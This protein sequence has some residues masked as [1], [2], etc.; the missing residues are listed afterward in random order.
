MSDHPRPRRIPETLPMDTLVSF[1]AQRSRVGWEETQWQGDVAPPTSVTGSSQVARLIA[2]GEPR[3]EPGMHLYRVVG[4][5]GFGEV[6]EALQV[7]LD[8]VVAVKRL[9]EETARQI[10]PNT[11]D[12]DAVANF[13]R[14]EARITARLEHPNIAPMHE[15]S[16]DSAGHPMLAMKMLRGTPWNEL[17]RGDF[18]VMEDPQFLERHL[19]ILA[20]M[21]QAV[22]FAHS[23]GVI[24]RDLKPTQVM[25][26]EFGEVLLLDWGLAVVYD[27]ERFG[28]TQ[29][30]VP[31]LETASSPAGTVAFMAPEQTEDD[32]TGVS[33]RTDVWLLGGCL[34]YILTGQL[35]HA[36][37]TARDT[38]FRAMEGVILPPEVRSPHRLIPRVLSDLSM[39][40]LQPQP[41]DRLASA[42]DF[43]QQLRDYLSG[44][45]RRREAEGL[46]RQARGILAQQR[47]WY[48]D[49]SA[50]AATLSRA[51]GLA[52][53]LDEVHSA[54]QQLAE[55]FAREALDRGDLALA[56]TQVE[57]LDSG[58]L[59]AEMEDRVRVRAARLRATRSQRTV[60]IAASLT[61]ATLL[62]IGGIYYAKE[63][64]RSREEIERALVAVAEQRDS[65]ERLVQEMLGDLQTRLSLLGRLDLMEDV[66]RLT[67]QYY[68]SMPKGDTVTSR[69]MTQRGRA[70]R[71]IGDVILSRGYFTEAES[72]YQDARQ[73]LFYPGSADIITIVERAELLLSMDNQQ[74]L[75][76]QGTDGK[77]IEEAIALLTPLLDSGVKT[78]ELLDT[79]ARA[80]FSQAEVASNRGELEEAERLYQ[81]SRAIFESLPKEQ[82]PAS[83][84]YDYLSLRSRIARIH[85]MLGK[86]NEAV[87][88]YED[89]VETLREQMDRTPENML[90][91]TLLASDMD[92]L[93]D[94]QNNL[95]QVARAAESLRESRELWD[96]LTLAQPDRVYAWHGSARNA[97]YLGTVEEV[98][99]SLPAAAAAYERAWEEFGQMLRR[100]ATSAEARR[101]RNSTLAR[102]SLVLLRMGHQD[103]AMALIRDS[104]AECEAILSATPDDAEVLNLLSIQ[105]GRLGDLLLSRGRFGE[106]LEEQQ[107]GI[108]ILERRFFDR[109]DYSPYRRQLVTILNR[110]VPTLSAMGRW[111]EALGRSRESEVIARRIA[112]EE[113]ENIAIRR[114]LAA[115]LIRQAP[116]HYSHR[117]DLATALLVAKEAREILEQ[118]AAG[119]FHAQVQREVSFALSAEARVHLRMQSHD[120]AREL[121]ESA[122]AI[123]DNL[124][125]QD[126]SHLGFQADRSGFHAALGEL[127]LR[128]GQ[129]ALALEHSSRCAEIIASL[130]ERLAGDRSMTA[131]LANSLTVEARAHLGIGDREAAAAA[132]TRA[133][134]LLEPF[135]AEYPDASIL[136]PLLE[137]YRI[138]GRDSERNELLKRLLDQ[139]WADPL[140]VESGAAASL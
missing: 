46:L 100:D 21:A 57:L 119:E 92:S 55:R 116:L 2:S 114:E 53:E 45:T 76:D 42:E 17:L 43:L 123:A 129:H 44:A 105:S 77:L 36:G 107:R 80:R 16:E 112:T 109:S 122:L 138:L 137:A 104:I 115:T 47:M 131:V 139:G 82:R 5:G 74:R 12:H 88:E 28:P 101:D 33:P 39:R 78:G 73:L 10:I 31:T 135:V 23:R 60:A 110:L 66:S 7:S 106:A 14:Q 136:A 79:F 49:L 102:H 29:D 130:Q 34:Y 111:E 38:F 64:Q 65:G 35:P 37:E 32:A 132:A 95:G 140:Y 96:R 89:L 93:A 97:Y 22:A 50:C 83:I 11:G 134:E 87:A 61:L 71:I 30:P 75:S 19:P 127:A 15:L 103:D 18:G 121:T 70:L 86:T 118:I 124:H 26:G 67:L 72:I 125:A 48:G 58:S 40:C 54:S 27:A 91:L 25:V 51:Q 85:G 52:P 6:W 24:H 68:S 13:F 81:E 69:E 1:D 4:R 9:R 3:V 94:L 117:P 59:R 120:R 126:P 133:V 63:Q 84:S 108:A 113:P 56:Q 8:R 62:A 41:A 128:Q 20:S 99:G 98:L 90:L